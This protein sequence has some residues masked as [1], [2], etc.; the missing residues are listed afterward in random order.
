M[1]GGLAV[2]DQRS[3]Y[4]FKTDFPGIPEAAHMS[5]Y[6]ALFG[7]LPHREIFLGLGLWFALTIVVA[8]WQARQKRFASHRSFIYRHIGAGIWVA[9]QRL[10]VFIM[11][12]LAQGKGLSE[13]EVAIR[14]KECFG[15]GAFFGVILTVTMAEV[16][17]YLSNPTLGTKTNL[18]GE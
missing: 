8:V 6:P 15:D 18:K 13:R 17:V 12:L 16:A 2:I 11:S 5:S 3:L 9:V 14:Q 10:Y 1:M 4:Y 7:A